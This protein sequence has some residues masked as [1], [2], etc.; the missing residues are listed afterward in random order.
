MEGGG[1]CNP[2]RASEGPGPGC[3]AIQNVYSFGMCI[4]NVHIPNSECTL[5]I[6]QNDAQMTPPYVRSQSVTGMSL[7]R[8]HCTFLL[9]INILTVESWTIQSMRHEHVR[10]CYSNV[11]SS[12]GRPEQ[13][14]CTPRRLCRLFKTGKTTEKNTLKFRSRKVGDRIG[15]F[16]LKKQFGGVC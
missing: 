13:T 1:C 4:Q 16:K 5:R 14:A 11:S 3:G 15:L 7:T 12:G 2:S 9:V 8:I 6:I 10:V